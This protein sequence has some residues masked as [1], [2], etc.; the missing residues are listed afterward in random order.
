MFTLAALDTES[1]N[2]LW[3]PCGL[4]SGFPVTLQG[5]DVW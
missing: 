2:G 5:R 1:H 4:K 3:G